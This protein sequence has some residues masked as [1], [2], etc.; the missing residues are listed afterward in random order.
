LPPP[1][2]GELWRIDHPLYGFGFKT[3]VD[4]RWVGRRDA[5]Q[6]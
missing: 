1:R 5:L 4:I 2:P 6:R 3:H